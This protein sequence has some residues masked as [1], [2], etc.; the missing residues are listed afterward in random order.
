MANQHAFED[1][2][3]VQPK[4]TQEMEGPQKHEGPVT[5]DKMQGKLDADT[6]KKMQQTVGNAAVQRFL[7]Q[8]SAEGA[9]EV[10]DETASTI[11]S[12]R[13]GGQ[14]LDENVA[15]QAGE[16]MGHD[17]S[18]VNVH[19]DGQSDKLNKD[20]GAKAFTTGSDIFFRDGAYNPGSDDGQRLISHE[21]THV[22]QQ[23]G[24]DSPGQGKL[25]VNDP[26]DQHEREADIV[27]ETVMGRTEEESAQR[28]EEE[29]VM[30]KLQRQEEEEEIMPKLQRQ[31]EEEEMLQ[32]KLQ[33]QEEEEVM[34]KLQRQEE[35]EEIM[36]KLQ[37][38]EEEE[39]ML[40]PKLQ[41]QEEE[42]DSVQLKLQRQE[43][44]EQLEAK[45]QREEMP[46]EELAMQSEEEPEEE[47]PVQTKL[48]REA[49]PEEELEMQPSEEEEEPVQTKL[50]RQEEIPEEAL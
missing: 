16:A 5:V 28:Q 2:G 3:K 15:A 41:R 44:E 36:P 42:E 45:L 12:K 30:P 19:T 39:E 18:D 31:E 27:A 4:P 23:S 25:T 32:P 48:Q 37:R 29:E 1:K 40:Q 47:E 10:D 24:S 9:G 7:A 49:M 33:R 21:L 46:E 13:G 20:L 17:F 35:E 8:R 14:S 50:Q 26:N 43:E 22:V 11:N 6:V 38:Q 34:P